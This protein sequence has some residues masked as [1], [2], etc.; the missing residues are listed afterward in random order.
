[1]IV[2]YNG[3]NIEISTYFLDTDQTIFHRIVWAISSLPEYVY[4]KDNEI[5]DIWFVCKHPT[6]DLLDIIS[7]Y[8]QF[9]KATIVHL[10]LLY[11]PQLAPF[12]MDDIR[13]LYKDEFYY[14]QLAFDKGEIDLEIDKLI[15]KQSEFAHEQHRIQVS[16]YTLENV[17]EYKSTELFTDMNTYQVTFT[18]IE[19]T[20]LGIFNNLH[21]SSFIPVIFS[22]HYYKILN[23]YSNV[24]NWETIDDCIV[25]KLDIGND[26][27]DAIIRQH[28]DVYIMDVPK[29]PIYKE[30]EV[31]DEIIKHIPSVSII[32]VGTKNVGG[33]FAISERIDTI[34]FADVLF[35]TDFIPYFISVNDYDLMSVEQYGSRQLYF[36]N[37]YD[38][39]KSLT[40]M[41][42]LK[43]SKK[44]IPPFYAGG[45]EYTS[46]KI[47]SATDNSIINTFVTL[48][49]KIITIYMQ[50]F[51]EISNMYRTLVP[52]A[53]QRKKK[54]KPI[55]EEEKEYDS[56]FERRFNKDVEPKI[57]GQTPQGKDYT[58]A[59]QPQS[60]I[61][62]I[63]RT[64]HEYLVEDGY[65]RVDDRLL[66]AV[67]F[68][69]DDRIAEQRY[70]V[71]TDPVYP[72]LGL[73]KHENQTDNYA[74][75]CFKS[76]QKNKTEYKNYF[77]NQMEEKEEIA[78]STY[79]ITTN[80]II[81]EGRFGVFPTSPH[82]ANH[83]GA[84]FKM[85]TMPVYRQGVHY[86]VHSFLECVLL[87]LRDY[88]YLHTDDVFE[89]V[90]QK[91][92]E[93]VK[94]A[95]LGMQEMYG[96]SLDNIENYITHTSNYLDPE[97]M[98]RIVEH[99]YNCNILLFVK[100]DKVPLGELIV[101][102]HVYGYCT[103]ERDNA[104]P[105]IFIFNHS[106]PSDTKL[107][108]L[109]CELIISTN[110]VLQDKSQYSS[111]WFQDNPVY[112]FCWSLYDKLT[113]YYYGKY[114][115]YP[116]PTHFAET[117]GIIQQHIDENGKV[118]L[119]RLKSGMIIETS[120]LPPFNVP[121]LSNDRSLS[122]W[123]S[124]IDFVK[125]Y[126]L[127]D[128]VENSIQNNIQG[129]IYPQYIEGWYQN[130]CKCRLYIKP[131]NY[132]AY[133]QY[134][135]PETISIHKQ[136][137]NNFKVARYLTNWVLY[138][139]SSFLQTKGNVVDIDKTMIKEFV[140]KYI[141]VF[142]FEYDA[143]DIPDRFDIKEVEG[144]LMKNGRIICNSMETLKRLLYQLR[145]FIER[146]RSNVATF[147][148]RKNMDSYYLSEDDF[149]KYPNEYIVYY[150]SEIMNQT[151]PSLVDEHS[152]QRQLYNTPPI[153]YDPYFLKNTQ[154]NDSV[155]LSQNTETIEQ[156]AVTSFLWSTKGYNA[157][158]NEY[159]HIP[160]IPYYLHI[161]GDAA[162][163]KVGDDNPIAH[164]LATPSTF[165][166]LMN[167]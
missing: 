46:V 67:R 20:L 116:T 122:D 158:D 151:L 143:E 60:R 63:I 16:M 140:D 131:Y 69:R 134:Y 123:D 110:N 24:R 32:S 77:T 81:T 33:F 53:R 14:F 96:E 128:I 121:L 125:R 10:W 92:L 113:E 37:P 31:V 95:V 49:R 157:Y 21:V 156:A 23:H 79:L 22:N 70:Y 39:S 160:D 71:C 11:H 109:H 154:I 19:T 155:V 114:P 57:F 45:M 162:T 64:T 118:R 17:E 90:V 103:F 127:Q 83:I 111:C 124:I 108:Y 153:G 144:K 85:S 82:I 15:K 78:S 145:L 147:Y 130:V 38:T 120:P 133:T 161:L 9:P 29:H 43:E 138:M 164:V 137:I 163:Y 7:K 80:K 152:A 59:C 4:Y 61:P 88:G 165:T 55:E 27:K 54:A 2:T 47:L 1:M 89:Y 98:I 62:K 115:I 129:D 28:N 58:K 117:F 12:I 87:A 166:S 41:M 150:N 132:S 104:K 34:V 8:P 146:D 159:E 73:L 35:T 97:R 48:Y 93:L 40:A 74:L 119:L 18:S 112:T 56:I 75:C 107:P 126:D 135:I 52:T 66:E 139:F 68:P 142:D 84:L 86:S 26:F 99:V 102:R 44:D 51:D 72:H 136:Y 149:T 76:E 105:S 100:D 13:D 6:S 30:T 25:C 3:Q 167:L 141:L 36:T 106:G 42:T 101:P 65:V 91:R 5:I 94:Y 148:T 50:R